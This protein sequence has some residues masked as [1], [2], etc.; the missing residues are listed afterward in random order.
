[1]ESSAARRSVKDWIGRSCR[2]AFVT[3]SLAAIPDGHF[4]GPTPPVGRF[5]EQQTLSLTSLS[6]TNATFGMCPC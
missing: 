5:V 4:A 6:S 2:G 1:M 3:G